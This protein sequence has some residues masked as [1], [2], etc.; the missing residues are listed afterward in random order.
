[1]AYWNE[2]RYLDT[3]IVEVHFIMSKLTREQ[4]IEI[5]KKRKQGQALVSLSEEYQ[6]RSEKI[7]YIVRLIDTHGIGILRSNKNNYYSP[8]LKL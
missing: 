7:R 4:K 3:Q 1:M 5:Y 2:P 6:I 8:E